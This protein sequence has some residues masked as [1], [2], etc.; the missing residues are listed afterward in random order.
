MQPATGQP[1]DV[2]LL[3][4]IYFVIFQCVPATA[5]SLHVAVHLT[6]CTFLFQRLLVQLLF[7]KFLFG[8]IHDKFTF[9]R[10]QKTGTSKLT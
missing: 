4:S 8:I 6:C 3:F 5:I 1:T 9:V 10:A 7:F 2:Q